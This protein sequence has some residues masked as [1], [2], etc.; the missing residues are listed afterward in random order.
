V[1]LEKKSNSNELL[2]IYTDL[3]AASLTLEFSELSSTA[4]EELGA[5][6]FSGEVAGSGTACRL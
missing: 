4:E 5:V 6:L 3:N 1:G 2:T